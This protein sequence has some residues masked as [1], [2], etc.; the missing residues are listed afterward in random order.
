[1]GDGPVKGGAVRTGLAAGDDSLK[2]SRI[3][4]TGTIPS[5]PTP[6]GTGPAPVLMSGPTPR[7][8][9]H[10]SVCVAVTGDPPAHL[11]LPARGQGTIARNKNTANTIRCTAP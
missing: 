2:H 8:A 7:S 3:C 10:L 6:G 1:M 11:M 9:S 5:A 4:G